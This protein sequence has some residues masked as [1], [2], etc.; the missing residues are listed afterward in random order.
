MFPKFGTKLS[1]KYKA[2]IITSSRFESNTI[3]NGFDLTVPMF[4]PLTAYEITTPIKMYLNYVYYLSLT[5]IKHF[6]AKSVEK[7]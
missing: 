5:K 4:N 3:R 2:S 1:M 6:F 7:Y